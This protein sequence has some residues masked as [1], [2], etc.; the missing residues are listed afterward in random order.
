M[1]FSNYLINGPQFANSQYLRQ[2]RQFPQDSSEVVS[3]TYCY[4]G[5]ITDDI[6]EYG[7]SERW[8]DGAVKVKSVSD[9]IRQENQ[10]VWKRLKLQSLSLGGLCIIATVGSGFLAVSSNENSTEALVALVSTTACLAFG[11]VGSIFRSSQATQEFEGWTD[12]LAVLREKR[13]LCQPKN[14]GITYV[15]DH[16]L[17]GVVVSEDE[18]RNIWI[19]TVKKINICFED[20][21]QYCCSLQA[22]AHFVHSFFHGNPFEVAN[23]HYAFASGDIYNPENSSGK[24]WP[25]GKINSLVQVF[26]RSKENYHSLRKEYSQSSRLIHLRTENEIAEN[27]RLSDLMKAP[28]IAAYEFHK[29][30]AESKRNCSLKIYRENLEESIRLIKRC[31]V[32][33][34][35]R[36]RM[37]KEAE[38]SYSGIPAV[39]EAICE[40][41]T[42]LKSYEQCLRLAQDPID[43]YFSRRLTP[44]KSDLCS[45]LHASQE[46]HEKNLMR[47]FPIIDSI[48][49]EYSSRSS[50]MNILPDLAFRP[51]SAYHSYSDVNFEDIIDAVHPNSFER[52][53]Y[54]SNAPAE[55][56]T[57]YLVARRRFA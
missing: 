42:K 32:D 29:T 9:P 17:T 20:L 15:K 5:V 11:A 52:M 33:S 36:R 49:K 21:K 26:S 56:E 57:F 12:P 19:G 22:K 50:G 46:Q 55:W 37:I 40:C 38:L 43:S 53:Y 51:P 7:Q 14:E 16:N 18:T 54:P 34:L 6:Q 39:R 24:I 30:Q 3:S 44:I 45:S 10:S 13:I 23:L 8:I 47:F 27:N 48:F 41:D 31:Y 28:F 4:R 35:E 25:R 1:S 2:H